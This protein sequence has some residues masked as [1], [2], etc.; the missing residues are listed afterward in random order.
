MVDVTCVK[1]DEFKSL[2]QCILDETFF[3]FQIHKRFFVSFDF[4]LPPHALPVRG[5][6]EW[7]KDIHFAV[8]ILPSF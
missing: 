7:I 2:K 8:F 1:N 5:G 3:F 4:L 6:R